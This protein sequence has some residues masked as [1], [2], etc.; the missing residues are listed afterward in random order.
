MVKRKCFIVYYNNFDFSRYNNINVVY[1]SQKEKYAVCYCDFDFY[2]NIKNK[3]KNDTNIERIEESL[4]NHT[5][6]DLVGDFHENYV[7]RYCSC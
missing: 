4:L 2:N 6:E 5:A 3:M 7:F 1:N